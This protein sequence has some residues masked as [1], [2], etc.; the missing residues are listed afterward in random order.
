LEYDKASV[1]L[2]Y[3][4]VVLGRCL[5]M[6]IVVERECLGGVEWWVAGDIGEK[7]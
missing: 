5:W 4:R 1:A 6:N 3:M 7:R 2:K